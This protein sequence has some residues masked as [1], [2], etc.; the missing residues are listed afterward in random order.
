MEDILAVVVTQGGIRNSYSTIQGIIRGT[1]CL[2]CVLQSVLRSEFFK[3][4]WVSNKVVGTEQINIR[5]LFKN[6]PLVCRQVNGSNILSQ[7]TLNK[8]GCFSSPLFLL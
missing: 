8:K 6:D 2:F 3:L 1:K 4:R 5:F 7:L